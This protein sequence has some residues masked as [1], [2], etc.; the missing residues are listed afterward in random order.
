MHSFMSD[1][2][3]SQRS[4]IQEGNEVGFSDF[5]CFKQKASEAANEKQ[6]NACVKN[7]YHPCTCHFDRPVLLMVLSQRYCV[8]RY[9][10]KGMLCKPNAILSTRN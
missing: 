5:G 3:R 10:A 1:W 6:V 2:Q 9:S 8:L 7:D 4:W